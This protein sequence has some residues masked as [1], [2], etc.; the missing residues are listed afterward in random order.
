MVSTAEI[1]AATSPVCPT[2]SALAKLQMMTSCRRLVTSA[3]SA[4]AMPG[5]LISGF[6]S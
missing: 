4:S 3:T 5:A 2:M 1:V 6:K